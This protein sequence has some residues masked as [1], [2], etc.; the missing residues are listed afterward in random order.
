MASSSKTTRVARVSIERAHCIC[1]HIRI[2]LT[3][4]FLLLAGA[5]AVMRLWF[6]YSPKNFE[7]RVEWKVLYIIL[8]KFSSH[9]KDASSLFMRRVHRPPL[10]FAPVNP[11]N[12]NSMFVCVF[13]APR[14]FC[15]VFFRCLARRANRAPVCGA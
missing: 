10:V 6:L 4:F 9:S 11:E 7:W 3:C 14:Q 8:Y 2:F 12:E 5:R 13:F 15:A 1:V